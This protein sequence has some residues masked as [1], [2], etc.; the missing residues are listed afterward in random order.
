MSAHGLSPEACPSIARI[1]LVLG[2]GA[3]ALTALLP[4]RAQAFAEGDLYLLSAGLPGVN[5]G[6]LLVD[7]QSGA[8][9]LLVDIPDSPE[10]REA[11]TFDPFRDRLIYADNRS[12]GGLVAVD[13]LGN[14]TD[15]AP[16][17]STPRHVTARAD[18]MLYLAGYGGGVVRYLDAS[19]VVHD[20]LNEPGTGVFTLGANNSFDEIIFDPAT[21]S[22]FFLT[23]EFNGIVAPCV[24]ADCVCAIRVPLTADGTQ[25][26]G[27]LDFCQ[28]NVSPGYE[29]VH[30]A[31]HTP[32]GEIL[33]TV[34]TNTNNQEPRMQLLDPAAMVLSTFASNGPYDG[35]GVTLAGTF[36][37]VRGQA[38]IH[39]SWADSLRAYSQGEVG[40]GDHFAGGVSGP[41]YGEMAQL[42]EIRTP[43]SDVPERQADNQ[44]DAHLLSAMPNPSGEGVLLTYRIA[45]AGQVRISVHD[46]A[47]RRVRVLA[48]KFHQ[49]GSYFLRW[50]GRD[51]RGAQVASGLYFLRI[52]T[53]GAHLSR[54]VVLLP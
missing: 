40:Y 17:V 31:G 24:L 34:D 12:T 33:V 7:P 51:G 30:G 15:L 4:E 23:G 28:T 43:G 45:V 1:V 29:K 35:A 39:D 22:L 38:V 25:V 49:T 21:N 44:A 13:L 47:G 19:D 46:F 20:L 8:T 53:N 14:R 52:E 16:T 54:K 37:G 41:G 26:A 48:N 36:S 3:V 18:G 32:T 5:S 42:I 27:P 50:N 2:L 6:I 11:F 9:S 10:L